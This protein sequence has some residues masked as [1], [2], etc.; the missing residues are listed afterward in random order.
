[1]SENL[2]GD[3]KT[4]IQEWHAKAAQALNLPNWKCP[5]LDFLS[6][7]TTTAGLAVFNENLIKINFPIYKNN[8]QDT[9]KTVC[10]HE[11]SHLAAFQ[12]YGRA[13]IGHNALWGGVMNKLGLPATRCHN[14]D[15]A[16]VKAPQ[17]TFQYKCNCKVHI[18]SAL[19][20]GKILKGQKFTCKWC[21][22]DV[23]FSKLNK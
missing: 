3:L 15:T 11:I 23:T 8:I 16:C 21:K 18:V 22:S 7:R 5:K 1:M 12:K 13:G 17:I 20:H 6:L 2:I 14:Y 9:L 10:G 4:S 19:D